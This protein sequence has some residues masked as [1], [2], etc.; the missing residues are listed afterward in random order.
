MSPDLKS[1]GHTLSLTANQEPFKS[2]KSLGGTPSGNYLRRRTSEADSREHAA[3][4]CVR[5]GWRPLGYTLI[6]PIFAGR[7]SRLGCRVS[8]TVQVF[9][10]ILIF[11]TM[12][13]ATFSKRKRHKPRGE[14]VDE[15]IGRGWSRCAWR[16][17]ASLIIDGSVSNSNTPPR[18]TKSISA[19]E[20]KAGSS[21]YQRS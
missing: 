17:I 3:N 5:A 13:T 16:L 14:Q 19:S 15:A 2:R 9:P 20:I 6:H 4:V 7:G 10:L 21:R 12:A 18:R 8:V 11:I 1:A